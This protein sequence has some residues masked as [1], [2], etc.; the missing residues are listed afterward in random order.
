MGTFQI[1]GV[2]FLALSIY[3]TITM[4]EAQRKGRTVDDIPDAE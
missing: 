2:I 3:E 4:G 1:I